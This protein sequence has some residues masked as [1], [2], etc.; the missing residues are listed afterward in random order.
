MM[1]NILGREFTLWFAVIAGAI[2]FLVTF[3]LGFLSPEQAALIITF[4]SAV[5]GAIAAWRTRPIAP[6][7]F[8]YAVSSAVALAGA[9]GLD[10]TQEQVGSFNLLVLSFLALM[11]RHQVSPF[12]DAHK[13]GVLGPK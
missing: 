9:Y 11:T 8:T 7:V 3:G 6:Q 4:I 13:T 5:F 1:K 10:L 12:E 2:N